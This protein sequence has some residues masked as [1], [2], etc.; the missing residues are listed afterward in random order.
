MNPQPIDNEGEVM[1]EH[2]ENLKHSYNKLLE[3]LQEDSA[4]YASTQLHYVRQRTIEL[5]GAKSY[6]LNHSLITPEESLDLNDI[7]WE[8]NEILQKRLQKRILWLANGIDKTI[9][10]RRQKGVY[11]DEFDTAT[12]LANAFNDILSRNFDKNFSGHPDKDWIFIYS[13]KNREARI[14]LCK[15]LRLAQWLYKKKILKTSWKKHGLK[16]GYIKNLYEKWIENGL[17]FYRIIIEGTPYIVVTDNENS[18]PEI[19]ENTGKNVKP[20]SFEWLIE[21]EER[22]RLCG[23]SFYEILLR[24]LQMYIRV[25][26]AERC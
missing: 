1:S 21:L 4:G 24:E 22:A 13:I 9:A 17:T 16:F 11:K 19:S 6:L 20:Y 18:Y 26:N 12:I 15:D 10:I 7:S 2:Y 23:P 3:T 5:S 14:W 8:I 25:Q